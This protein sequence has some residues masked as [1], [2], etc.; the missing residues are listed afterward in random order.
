MKSIPRL[1]L[2]TVLLLLPLAGWSQAAADKGLPVTTTPIK[3]NLY[4]L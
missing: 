3:G 2:A 4:L 1:T